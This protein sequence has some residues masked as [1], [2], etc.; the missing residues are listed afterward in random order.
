LCSIKTQDAGKVEK[1]EITPQGCSTTPL[2]EMDSTPEAFARG[3]PHARREFPWGHSLASFDLHEFQLQPGAIA[4]A[5]ENLAAEPND[6]S[7]RPWIG[8]ERG[9]QTLL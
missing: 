8:P 1:E 5:N 7:V 2:A 3:E 6:G 4:A 9:F